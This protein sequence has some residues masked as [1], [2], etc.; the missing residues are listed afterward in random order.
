MHYSVKLIISVS[1]RPKYPA[2][3]KQ[4]KNAMKASEDFSQFCELTPRKTNRDGRIGSWGILFCFVLLVCLWMC[5]RIAIQSSSLL[6]WT[7]LE[8]THRATCRPTWYGDMASTVNSKDTP[9]ASVFFFLLFFLSLVCAGWTIIF[10]DKEKKENKEK[11][12]RFNKKKKGARKKIERHK[13]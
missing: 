8:D 4:N 6:P 13:S 12:N 11:K 1:F 9:K 2:R 5:E 3:T 7:Q 10:F